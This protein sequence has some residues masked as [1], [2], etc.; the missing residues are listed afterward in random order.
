MHFQGLNLNLLVSLDAL[1][2]ERSVTRAAERVHVTQPAMSASL[3]Q[4]RQH[5]GDA[6]LQQVG[7]QLELT[8]RGRALAAPVKDLLVRIDTVL[9]AEP[10]FAPATT[11][12]TFNIAMSGAMVELIGVR[13]IRHLMQSAPK[14]S[15]NIV[16]LATDSL[17]DVEEGRL[18]FCITMSERTVNSLVN[19][20]ETLSSEQLY[21]DSF[22]IVAALDN[23]AVHGETTYDDLCLMPYI[24]LRMGGDLKSIPT[25]M[26]DREIRRPHVIA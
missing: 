16:D 24:E 21:S 7:R 8:P 4:L 26:L 2:T 13:L 5:L 10:V 17:R 12:R 19:V 18:D 14:V 3:N 20:A 9:N 6:L 25:L 1:L 23:V 11:R 15:V 22:V